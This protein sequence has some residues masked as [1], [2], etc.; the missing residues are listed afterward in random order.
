MMWF[1]VSRF[2]GERWLCYTTKTRPW[3]EQPVM[4]RTEGLDHH[5][6]VDHMAV[7]IAEELRVSVASA[8][9]EN[10]AR[11]RSNMAALSKGVRNG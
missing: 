1:T 4:I 7:A 2:T 9:Y 10:N 8:R 11:F 3:G 6:L 5:K